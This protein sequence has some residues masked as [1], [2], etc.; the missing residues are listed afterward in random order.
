MQAATDGSNDGMFLRNSFPTRL[1][2]KREPTINELKGEFR[3]LVLGSIWFVGDDPVLGRYGSLPAHE[4][5]ADFNLLVFLASLESL[6]VRI[7]R[8]D[9]TCGVMS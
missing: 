2:L 7:R 1:F 8:Y 6:K 9:L 5:L 3:R 4:M